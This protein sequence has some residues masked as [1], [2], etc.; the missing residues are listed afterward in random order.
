MVPFNE[1]AKEEV[2]EWINELFLAC[3]ED[4]FPSAKKQARVMTA[5]SQFNWGEF[6][7]IRLQIFETSIRVNLGCLVEASD[8][9]WFELK[10]WDVLM[11]ILETG[12]DTEELRVAAFEAVT[13]STFGE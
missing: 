5:I 12:V 8:M 2:A 6:E 4:G 10:L 13:S 1:S 9:A 3:E 7:E 11:A